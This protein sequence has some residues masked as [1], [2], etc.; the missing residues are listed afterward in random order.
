MTAVP[1]SLLFVPGNR[2]DRF[3]KALASGADMVVL[4]L[5]DAVLPVDKAAARHA[6]H[7]ALASGQAGIAVR[8]NGVQ[9]AWHAEDARALAGLPGLAAAMIPKA[10]TIDDFEACAGLGV[11]LIGLI[12]TVR[13]AL[14]LRAICGAPRVARLAFGT[15]DF[16]IDAGINGDEAELDGVR[17]MMVLQ[18]RAAGLPPP[19]DGVSVDIADPENLRRAAARSARHGF[20]GKLCVHP[21]QVQAVNDAFAPDEAMIEWAK[22]VLVAFEGHAVATLDGALVDKPVADR[23]RSILRLSARA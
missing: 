3:A 10:E 8:L 9:T 19:I 11:P 21:N 20:G 22:N 18:S 13:G 2:P 6:V 16:Q 14:A 23:A 5:E 12:E 4:D 17:S 1:R 15:L 7:N